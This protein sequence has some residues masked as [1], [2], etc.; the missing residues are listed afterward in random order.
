MKYL[1]FIDTNIF[2]DFYRIRSGDFSDS[3]LSHIDKNHDKIITGNQVEMEF[4]KNRQKVILETINRIKKP[5]WSGLTPPACLS[6]AKP[7]K[8]IQKNRKELEKQQNILKK[9]MELILRHPVKNDPVYQTL[10]RL[11]KDSTKYNLDRSMK[12]RRSIRSLAW[13]RFFLGYPP[14]KNED[15]SMGDAVNWEWIIHCAIESKKNVVIVSRDSDY[16]INY[17]NKYFL[18]DALLQEFR[19][20]VSKKRKIEL[21]DKLTHAFKLASIP[22]SRTEEK[23]EEVLVSE[24]KEEKKA[25]I[26]NGLTLGEIWQNKDYRR[27]FFNVLEKFSL[28]Q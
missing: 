6:A 13:K 26:L 18:N 9:R 19:E 28:N 17:S 10:Q 25:S 24:I 27:E 15:V 22:V 16:G 8:V 20:R 14:R 11:F 2:L 3:L 7:V 4:K 21:T 1:I 23:A 5:D 12:I